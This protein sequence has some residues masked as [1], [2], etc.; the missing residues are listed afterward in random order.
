LGQGLNRVQIYNFR[1][2]MIASNA[3][4]RMQN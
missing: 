3:D 1:Q 2:Y 4:Y